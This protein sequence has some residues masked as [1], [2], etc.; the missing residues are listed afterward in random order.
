MV[1]AGQQH[2]LRS[3]LTEVLSGLKWDNAFFFFVWTFSTGK[4]EESG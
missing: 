4:G 3:L 2:A 1:R